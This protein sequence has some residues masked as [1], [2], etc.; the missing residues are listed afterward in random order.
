M[1]NWSRRRAVVVTL[2]IAALFAAG[3]VPAH[4]GT[5]PAHAGAGPAHARTA[6]ALPRVV[7]TAHT[8]L[9]GDRSGELPV[10]LP[11]PTSIVMLDASGW[12]TG[13]VG[14]GRFVGFELRLDGPGP[15]D[16]VDAIQTGECA[17]PGCRPKNPD[18]IN[19]G[20]QMWYGGSTIYLG[21]SATL[22]AGDYRLVFVADGAP[23]RVTLPVMPGLG[24]RPQVLSHWLPAPVQIVAAT[25][26]VALPALG[27]TPAGGPVLFAAG[28]T[29]PMTGWEASVMG[30]LWADQP[31][32]DEGA[33]FHTCMYVPRPPSGPVPAYAGGCSAGA[34]VDDPTGHGPSTYSGPYLIGGSYP[35]GPTIG[36]TRVTRDY[37]AFLSFGLTFEPGEPPETMSIGANLTSFGPT[38][39]AHLNE[40]WIDW[41][42]I[43]G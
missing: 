23:A 11:H 37:V 30:D 7:L 24:G 34:E 31:L 8:V 32:P 2:V 3:A 19:S 21:E 38:T 40:L 5:G 20:T 43:P 33:V 35:Y 16:S 42:P 39:D 26:T 41:R 17:T 15:T 10:Y 9:V 27:A 29:R 6:R 13:I 14:N 22:P 1:S 36:G 18:N 4:A 25:P 28:A 12:T